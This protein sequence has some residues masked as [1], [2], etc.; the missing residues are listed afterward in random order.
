[1]ELI[2]HPK[3]DK[4]TIEIPKE[5]VNKDLVIKPKND[6]DELAGSI[7]IPKEKINYELEKRAWEIAVLEKYGKLKHD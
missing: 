2:I 3:E 6:L 7:K 5:W 4:I 1:M